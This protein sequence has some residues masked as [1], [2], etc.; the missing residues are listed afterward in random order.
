[1]HKT[2]FSNNHLFLGSVDNASNLS[3]NPNS[4]NN[5]ANTDKNNEQNQAET[6]ENGTRTFT[7]RELAMATKNFK[8]ECVIGEGVFG[9]LYKAKLQSGEVICTYSVLT[10]NFSFSYNRKLL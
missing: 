8:Q 7:F 6:G 1:M 4:K 10:S 3:T 9:K 2:S 5:D